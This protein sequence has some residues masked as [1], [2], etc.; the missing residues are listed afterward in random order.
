MDK[1]DEER[2]QKI[3][4]EQIARATAGKTEVS[5]SSHTLLSSLFESES[6]LPSTFNLGMYFLLVY[7]KILLYTQN[8]R[9]KMRKRKVCQNGESLFMPLNIMLNVCIRYYTL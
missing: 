2:S 1:D 6:S 3:I 5:S 4:E 9:G 7:R 8:C